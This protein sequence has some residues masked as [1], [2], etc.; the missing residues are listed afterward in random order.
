MLSGPCSV[1]QQQHDFHF[2]AGS[3]CLHLPAKEEVGPRLGGENP[4]G[5]KGFLLGLTHCLAGTYRRGIAGHWVM[6]G[7]PALEQK[8]SH[9]LGLAVVHFS[10]HWTREK[11]SCGA[12]SV[13]TW[14]A[15]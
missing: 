7:N 1:L 5:R 13:C 10:A 8:R 12:C 3:Q 11:V 14:Y 6:Q 15:L 4:A 9:T 2:R